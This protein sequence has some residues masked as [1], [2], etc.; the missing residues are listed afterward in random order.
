M[1]KV[2]RCAYNSDQATGVRYVNT[3]HVVARPGFDGSEASSA[4]VR[5]ALHTAL[6]TKYRAVL[7]TDVTVQ[8]LVVREELAP[9]DSGVPDEASQT[10]GLA[11]TL[12]L[13]GDRLPIPLCALAT[14]YTNAAV[15]S[16]HGR[17][18]LPNPGQAAN[19][20]STSLWDTG[21]AWF[22]TA[23]PAFLN[24]LKANHSA[25]IAGHSDATCSQVIYS[26]T[27]RGRGDAA[28]YFDVVSYV[29]RQQAHWLRSRMTAP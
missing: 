29:V 21:T 4:A 10:I 17:M 11:G 24:E 9:T 5:D 25:A 22:G 2:F 20:Q 18:F 6:T 26:R 28:Y 23:L 3:F 7:P 13:S 8:S 1:A 16:G 19:L 14:F 12:A 15:R 27:R